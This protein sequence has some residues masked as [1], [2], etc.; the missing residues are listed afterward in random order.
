MGVVRVF[1]LFLVWGGRGDVAGWGLGEEVR[2]R[3]GRFGLIQG[4]EVSGTAGA[5]EPGKG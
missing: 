4:L 3:Q 2:F 5:G 1:L